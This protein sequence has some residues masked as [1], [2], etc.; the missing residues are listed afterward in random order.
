MIIF[1]FGSCIVV[2]HGPHLWR[3][4]GTQERTS[5]TSHEKLGKHWPWKSSCCSWPAPTTQALSSHCPPLSLPENQPQRKGT[6]LKTQIKLQK[7]TEKTKLK[8]MYTFPDHHTSVRRT[9]QKLL[10]ELP[11]DGAVVH[12]QHMQ[13][14]SSIPTTIRRRHLS[15]IQ[16]E[17]NPN[18][19][20]RPKSSFLLLSLSVYMYI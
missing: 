8:D 18:G 20:H 11:V 10:Y 2:L 7:P 12:R 13:L 16:W 1:T 17:Q 5:K 4:K 9:T 14:S 15:P 19:K 3:R 6:E